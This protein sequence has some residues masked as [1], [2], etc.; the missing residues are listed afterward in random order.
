MPAVRTFTPF[1]LTSFTL[2][3]IYIWF[4]YFLD[5]SEFGLLTLLYFGALA[6]TYF[7]I[8]SGKGQLGALLGIGL[9]FRLLFV[10]S[11]PGLSQDFFRFIWD[12]RLILSGMN[13]YLHTPDNLIGN[14]AIID[15]MQELYKGMGS[16]SAGHYS[17]YPPL[18]QVF[19]AL[20]A[21]LGG[22][23]IT[24]PVVALRLFIVLSDLGI[25]YFGSRLLK[26][27]GLPPQAIL[28]YFLNPFVIIE[29]TGNLHFEGVML[30][31]LIVSLYLLKR[32]KWVLSAVFFGLSVSVKLLPL[33]FIPLFYRFFVSE[34][35]FSKGFW[36]LKT[37]FWVALGTFL[38]SFAP[39]YSSQLISNYTN[40]IGLWFN[41][42]E[43]NASV[44]YL[45]RWI[46]FEVNG[47]DPIGTVGKILPPVV[48]LVVLL[49]AFIRKNNT[50]QSL[51]TSMLFAVTAYLLL[52]TT[53]HPWYLATPL[54]LS[55]FTRWRYTL[56]WTL[57]VVLSYSAYSNENFS[58]NLWLVAIEYL[59]VILWFI[60]EV[61]RSKK[62]RPRPVP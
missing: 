50:L 28:L 26:S 53:V 20:S 22:A 32:K 55:V 29:L 43:F 11:L 2:A 16:L 44:F 45:I 25:V 39:F 5:R 27:M 36:R 47:W 33:L 23:G 9:L 19:F 7:L 3:T 1:L 18:N 61:L 57:M 4:G 54:L 41:N 62:R 34:G 58:E 10:V 12:G 6:L 17:N 31:F 52:S 40:T 56:I 35:L 21:W 48:L 51:F 15:N 24:L 14:G 60:W 37:Y 49:L 8:K 59:V 42:F 30:F 13:P 38:L 46:G